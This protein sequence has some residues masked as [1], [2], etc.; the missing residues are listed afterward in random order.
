MLVVGNGKLITRNNDL[1]FIDN[2]AVAIDGT[3]I[4]EIGTTSEIKE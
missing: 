1:P 3:K 4:A 2:G